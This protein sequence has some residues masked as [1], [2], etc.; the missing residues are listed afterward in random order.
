MEKA[1]MEVEQSSDEEEAGDEDSE[2]P[3][4]A[5]DN[6]DEYNEHHPLYKIKLSVCLKPFQ[7]PPID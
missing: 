7:T 3:T 4:D 1:A 6:D 5:P 2:P